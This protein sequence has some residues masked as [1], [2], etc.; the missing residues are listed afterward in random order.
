MGNERSKPRQP[1]IPSQALLGRQSCFKS[2]VKGQKAY[3][4]ALRVVKL[5]SAR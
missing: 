3:T 1:A 4:A 2:V 5:M